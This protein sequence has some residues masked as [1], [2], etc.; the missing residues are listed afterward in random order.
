M[1]S[2]WFATKII[3]LF[4]SFQPYFLTQC[5]NV[6]S[7]ACKERSLNFVLVR[8]YINKNFLHH[9]IHAT[10][11]LCQESSIYRLKRDSYHMTHELSYRILE[12]HDPFAK[13]RH[14][15]H[16]VPKMLKVASFQDISQIHDLTNG[17]VRHLKIDTT[18]CNDIFI[19]KKIILNALMRLTS[20][21]LSRHLHSTKS[22]CGR[23]VNA[24]SSIWQVI[25]MFIRCGFNW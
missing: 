8:Y 2:S 14:G 7:K 12:T 25:S 19:I 22:V 20:F 3:V 9:T 4:S 21:S 6:A 24:L 13:L 18:A 10:E 11:Q 15:Q 17:A 1:F 5:F 16:P 23:L